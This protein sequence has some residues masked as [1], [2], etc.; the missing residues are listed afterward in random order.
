MK[1]IVINEVGSVSINEL[2]KPVRKSGEVLLRLLYGGICGS[3]LGTYRG[4][5]AYV[6]YPCIPGHEFS[7]EVVEVE[8]NDKGIYVGQIVTCNPYFNCG[9]CYSCER[10]IVNACMDNQTM[11]VQ[12]EGAFSEYLAMPM[13]R[14]YDGQ[15]LDPKSLALVEPFCISYHGVK[16]ANVCEKDTV[17]VIG[18][19]GIGV[20][21][22]VAAKHKGA[23]VYISD[24]AQ[25][26][27]DYA[28]KFGLDGTILNSSPEA[29][30][31]Q[32]E[33]VTNG[34]GFDVCIEAVGMP[35]TFQSCID[36]AAFGG[37]VVLIGISKNNLDFN[38]TAIQKK[39]LNVFG[40]RNALQE[41]FQEVIDIVKSGE[42]D[43]HMIIT[44]EYEMEEAADA[45]KNF[46]ANAGSTLKVVL[47]FDK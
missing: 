10:G 30:A 36:S 4:S 21:A 32:V 38:F 8:E 28:M 22:A 40:S 33:E 37:R 14:V 26:K 35:A 23:K 24:I 42:V 31:A 20:L 13:E 47:K 45:F 12:R 19:G 39:E 7:A 25:D 18:A 16:R 43:L 34:N 27:L 6:K 29:F 46:A 15:G 2:E 11:G 1:Q 17:L 44:N 9:G 3:D 5:N 41:D